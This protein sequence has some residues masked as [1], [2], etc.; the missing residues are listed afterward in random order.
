MAKNNSS[1]SEDF[2][3]LFIRSTEVCTQG[4]GLAKPAR[5]QFNHAP[6]SS[7]D[8]SGNAKTTLHTFWAS[9]NLSVRHAFS[10]QKKKKI[11]PT[12]I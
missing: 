2:V 5:Y 10:C 7:E 8:F 9:V 12:M 1:F 11:R 6:S 4:L 3:Y